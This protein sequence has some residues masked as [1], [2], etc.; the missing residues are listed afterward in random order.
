L[1]LDGLPP[2]VDDLRDEP[3]GPT[4]RAGTA[5]TCGE[6]P[7]NCAEGLASDADRQNSSRRRFASCRYGVA[8]DRQRPARERRT[9]V[10]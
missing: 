8:T 6:R 10:T 2:D 3:H 7:D 1:D 9:V 4:R 5:A